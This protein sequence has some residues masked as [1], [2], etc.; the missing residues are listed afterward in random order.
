MPAR[1]HNSQYRERCTSAGVQWCSKRWCSICYHPGGVTH[2]RNLACHCQGGLVYP[3]PPAG[4]P[5]CVCLSARARVPTCSMWCI[6]KVMQ[7][8]KCKYVFAGDAENVYLLSFYCCTA[9][10]CTYL[11]C[12]IIKSWKYCD[13]A[14]NSQNDGMLRRGFWQEVKGAAR[15]LSSP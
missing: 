9:K 6:G 1:E 14:T 4:L 8:M 15:H 13:G 11:K 3:P 5:K 2:W 10:L 7:I 12:S